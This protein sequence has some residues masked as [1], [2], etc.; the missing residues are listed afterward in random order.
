ML[1]RDL[2]MVW[3]GSPL[4]SV[5]LWIGVGVAFLYLA[6]FPAH[7]AI[8]SFSRMIYGVL[9]LASRSTLLMERR[10]VAR[11]REVMINAEMEERER[12]LAREFQRIAEA[13]SA[14]L[15]GYPGL[16]QTLMEQSG[17]IEEEYR[18]SALVP[19]PP[20]GWVRAVEVLAKL[21]EE[22]DTSVVPILGYIHK[23]V[24]SQFHTAMTD[25]NRAVSERQ[26]ILKRIMPHWRKVPE[27]LEEIENRVKR[28]EERA[29]LVD[30]CM[31]DYQEIRAQSDQ[32][33]RALTASSMAR[34]FTAAAFLLIALGGVVLNFHL[35]ALPM[36]EMV[37]GGSYIGS[38]K[39]S[40]VAALVIIFVEFAMGL[41]LME[42]LGITRLFP[43]LGQ[44]DDKMRHRLA[45]FAFIILTILA[46]VEASLAYVRDQLAGELQVFQESLARSQGAQPMST[47]IPVTGQMVIAFVL[48]YALTFGAIPLE[49]LV[50]TGR[51]VL[52]A[53]VA[54]ALRWTAFALR[55]LGHLFLHLGRLAVQL[56]DL[57]IVPPLWVE[58][59]LRYRCR[60]AEGFLEEQAP[61]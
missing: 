6:R 52:G 4:L 58:G 35:I 44:L 21:P 9:R 25:Y 32:A 16:Q 17:K 19:P 10:V 40:S 54:A 1:H 47:W 43:A 55:A 13:V 57:L 24:E 15:S 31:A 50:K 7:R 30:I 27:I 33:V 23:T 36:S 49:A 28:L 26:A 22:G 56:Y 5:L 37:G 12:S 59:L 20:P 34:F 2:F 41:Y 51:S 3:P 11:T 61:Q 38:F 8:I 45:M 18:N 39:S 60:R 46:G 53:T 29:K 14:D 48:P 42:F